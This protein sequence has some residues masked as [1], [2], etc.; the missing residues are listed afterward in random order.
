MK[1]AT[2][3]TYQHRFWAN[4]EK[5]DTC[6]IWRGTVQ[7]GYGYGIFFRA[8]P[9][10]PR[11]HMQAHRLSYE[12]TTGHLP[13][14]KEHVCHHC[15]NPLCVNPAHLFIGSHQDNMNDCKR[16]H[17]SAWGERS[18][19]AKLSTDDVI[20]IRQRAESS[21]NWD[22]YR[23]LASQHG[24]TATHIYAI[25]KGLFWSHPLET[26]TALEVRAKTVNTP[27]TSTRS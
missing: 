18:G 24:V 4:V 9:T 22:T 11:R 6:W 12:F 27:R 25:V 13:S 15:D 2:D 3:A 1:A 10:G 17:R 16:K 7:H 20:A 19:R 8:R 5:T 14:T 21:R 23:E 26:D